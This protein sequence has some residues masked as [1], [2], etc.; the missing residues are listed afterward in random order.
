VLNAKSLSVVCFLILCFAILRAPASL[1]ERIV[2]NQLQ[3]SI[4]F[5][6]SAGTL[7]QGSGTIS[8]NG[9]IDSDLSWS[10]PLQDILTLNPKVLWTI[11]G[12]GLNLKGETSLLYQG[13]KTIA[14]GQI[15]STLLNNAFTP[16]DVFLDGDLLIKKI[17]IT[18]Q[19]EENFKITS[20]TGDLHWTGGPIRYV[21]SQT[22]ITV[23]S[24]FFQLNLSDQ[25]GGL[26]HATLDSP[27]HGYHLLIATLNPTKGI[28]K[29]Q[30]SK[31]FTKIFG[32]E[33][34]GS[35]SDNQIVLEL[36]ERIF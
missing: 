20:L 36:E 18:N 31:G 8:L 27:T 6:S 29:M 22:P 9:F 24:P 25:T 5:S 7:W 34:P 32:N 30:V 11:E 21:L 23:I 13:S 12:V 16:Y 19:I 3:S 33:W 26:I 10:I 2:D 1:I 15:Y 4:Q 17:S 28:L 14:K 35:A